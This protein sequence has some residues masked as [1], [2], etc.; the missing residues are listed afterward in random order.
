[1]GR[2]ERN[3]E[4]ETPTLKLSKLI[5]CISDTFQLIFNSLLLW[6]TFN[7]ASGSKTVKA[8]NWN[9]KKS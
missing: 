5:G 1:M 3:K 6:I 8:I 4:K 2:K 7:A 9:L